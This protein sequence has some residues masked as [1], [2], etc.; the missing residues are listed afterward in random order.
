MTR[1]ETPWLLCPD[2]YRHQHMH[3][4]LVTFLDVIQLPFLPAPPFALGVGDS[5]RR[6]FHVFDAHG[7]LFWHGSALQNPDLEMSI[8]H[9]INRIL[10]LRR[11]VF[12][13]IPVERF[14]RRGAAGG[15]KHEGCA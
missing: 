12:S 13:E 4:S 8:I 7:V 2:D 6:L 14:C 3:P 1:F 11:K 10:R 15:Q 5:R 9:V